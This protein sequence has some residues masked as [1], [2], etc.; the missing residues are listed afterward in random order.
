MSALSDVPRTCPHRDSAA[1]IA[2]RD[3]RIDPVRQA[4]FF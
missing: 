4:L 1:S 3:G 2:K